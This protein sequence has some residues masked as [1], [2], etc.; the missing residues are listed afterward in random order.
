M[1]VFEGELGDFAGVGVAQEEGGAW[2]LD[3]LRAFVLEISLRFGRLG[4]DLPQRIHRV[5]T[6]VCGLLLG[7]EKEESDEAGCQL[8]L[9]WK[10]QKIIEY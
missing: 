10:F 7:G 3:Y 1:E 5:Q 2:I 6:H 4:L 8:R 9:D